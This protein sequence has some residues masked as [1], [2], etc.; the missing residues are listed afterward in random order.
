MI[1]VD[2]LE[3]KGEEHWAFYADKAANGQETHGDGE[4]CLAKAVFLSFT[5]N[6]AAAIKDTG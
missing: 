4:R 1:V 5:T 6:A 3:K 2:S